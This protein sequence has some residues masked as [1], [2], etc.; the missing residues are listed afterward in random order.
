MRKKSDSM[1]SP[2]PPYSLDNVPET[3]TPREVLKYQEERPD[4]WSRYMDKKRKRRLELRKQSFSQRQS[5]YQR[6]REQLLGKSD[7]KPADSKP[8]DSKP[9]DSK[10]AKI[11]PPAPPTGMGMNVS[12]LV[13][14][15]PLPSTSAGAIPYLPTTAPAPAPAPAPAQPVKYQSSNMRDFWKHQYA[16]RRQ[17][18]ASL[19]YMDTSLQVKQNA[20][21]EKLW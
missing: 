21:V 13:G 6:E 20:E 18:F 5:Q 2:N 15:L 9:A 4:W 14:G 11:D 16:K 8:A 7:S 1:D 3:L 10:P 17:R 12:S 19:L